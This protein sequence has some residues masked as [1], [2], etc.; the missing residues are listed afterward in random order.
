VTTFTWDWWANRSLRT[1]MMAIASLAAA[2]AGA[3]GVVA[4][5][6]VSAEQ[7]K[8]N[9]VAAALNLSTTADHL[10]YLVSDLSNQESGFAFDAFA[11]GGKQALG[12]QGDVYFQSFNSDVPLIQ[13]A[14]KALS[15][16]QL[17]APEKANLADLTSDFNGFL[18]IEGNVASILKQS[19]PG[20]DP[21]TDA[22]IGIAYQMINGI[23]ADSYRAMVAESQ[24]L[25]SAAQA[26][27][28]KVETAGAAV[29]T[30]VRTE[31][32][33]AFILGVAA[34]LALAFLVSR[35]ILAAVRRITQAV[36]DLAAG[37]LTSRTGSTTQDEFGR[38]GAE[39]DHASE[40]VRQVVASVVGTADRLVDSAA[41]L[42]SSGEQLATGSA[43]VTHQA[44]VVS[45]VAGDV[46]DSV[47]TVAHR[48]TEVEAAINEIAKNAAEAS[49]VANEASVTAASVGETLSRLGASSV[50]IGTV[51][52]LIDGIAEQTNLLALNATIESAHA[53]LAGKGFAVVASEVKD[54]AQETRVASEDISKRIAAIQRDTDS[55]INMVRQLADVI[56]HIDSLQAGIAAAVEEQSVITQDVYANVR[57]AATGSREIASSIDLVATTAGSTATDVAQSR[58]AAGQLAAM[59]GELQELVHRFRWDAGPSTLEG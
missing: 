48:A 9:Q 16:A 8:A 43:N 17:T 2:S 32:V 27:T 22:P 50:Q 19:G 1:K 54:L 36:R 37:D 41:A 25:S 42:T 28:K 55:A 15:R 44:E 14:V 31:V 59:A 49:R 57:R 5:A 24:R 34:A 33:I 23:Q 10:A 3:V 18:S 38:I 45:T 47:Q 51:M 11:V 39:L 26:S 53:G 29:V 58:A 20:S 21:E 35:S 30:R 52:G 6:G 13:E 4:L 46:S 56:G 40:A 12:G 7:A